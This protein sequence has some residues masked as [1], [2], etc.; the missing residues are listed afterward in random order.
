MNGTF[1]NTTGEKGETLEESKRAVSR[2]EDII[3]GFFR[4]HPRK[5]FTPFEVWSS[6][7]AL[8]NVPITSIRRAITNLTESGFLRK[9][10]TKRTGDYGK[11]NHLWTVNN[12]S[13]VQLGLFE[14][15]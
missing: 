13:P 11:V 1:Y 3:L 5:H 2:Q 15:R 7:P 8:A 10:D 14:E 9:L 4:D 6:I 12:I